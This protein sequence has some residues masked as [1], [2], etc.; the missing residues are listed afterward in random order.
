M[1]PHQLQQCHIVA[2]CERGMK[3]RDGRS[4]FDTV[5]IKAHILHGGKGYKWAGRGWV[6]LHTVRLFIMKIYCVKVVNITII[7]DYHF[8][9]SIPYICV[10]PFQ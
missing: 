9:T 3:V 4:R 7:L 1:W 2:T 8:N 10:S 5:T 6:E